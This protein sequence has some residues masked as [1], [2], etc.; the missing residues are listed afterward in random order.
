VPPSS[1]P[2][3]AQSFEIVRT[4]SSNFQTIGRTARSLSLQMRSHRRINTLAA[5]AKEACQ[6]S[7]FGLIRS[8]FL[9]HFTPFQEHSTW[10][11][12]LSCLLPRR[13]SMQNLSQI[14]ESLTQCLGVLTVLTTKGNWMDATQQ[15][16][17]IQAEVFTSTSWTQVSGLRTASL[18]GELFPRWRLRMP[19]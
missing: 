2:V 6:L 3:Q 8:S 13:T 1:A 10:R 15:E 14:R 4:G 11:W 9:S 7:S 18:V 16:V 5:L 17:L 12:T 19:K